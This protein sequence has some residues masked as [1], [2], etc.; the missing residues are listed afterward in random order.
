MDNGTTEAAV[1][2]VFVREEIARLTSELMKFIQESEAQK[3]ALEGRWH[4]N[5]PM[6]WLIHCL[7]DFDH[8][9]DLFVHRNDSMDWNTLQNRNSMGKRAS[10]CWELMS[11]KWNDPEFNPHTIVFE[12]EGQCDELQQGKKSLDYSSVKHFAAATPKKCKLKLDEMMVALKRIIQHW[13]SSGQGEG[14][15]DNDDE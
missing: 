6:L 9:C 13:E 7:I 12:T 4:G 14:G 5:E 1:D 10:T 11:D 8:I 2:V 15:N 3:E